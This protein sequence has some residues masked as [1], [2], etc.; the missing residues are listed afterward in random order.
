MLPVISKIL[1]NVM[2]TQYFTDNNLLSSQ[3]YGFRSNRSTELATLEIM[4]RNIHHMNENCCPVNIYLDFSKAFDSL[5]YDILLSK[6]AYYGIQP[7]ALRLLTSYLQD[8]CQ[9][10]QLDNV[11]S[12][13]HP[14]TC[15]IPQGSVLGPLLF[16]VFINDITF[17]E[18]STKFD[19]IMYA[20]DTTLASTLENFGTLNDVT[21]LERELNQEITKVYSWLLSNK[22]MLTTAKSKFM[23]FFKVPKV[24]SRLSLTIAGNPIEQVNEFN[25]LGITL[26]QNITW[27]PHITKMAI[28]IARV[29]G[30]LNKLKHI[31]PQHILLTIYNSLIQP[32]FIYGLYLWG[33]NCKRLKILQKKAV[34]ILAFRPYI[35]HSTPIFKTLKILKLEDLYTMQLYKFY[36]KNTNNLLPSYFNSFT[37][38]YNNENHNHDLRY[39]IL[40]LPMT[41]H[42]YY[43]QC[44]KYQ[45]L[46]LIRE[47]PHIDRCT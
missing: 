11:K 41:R 33:L 2:H 40:R 37:P 44:T 10:V 46:R 18:A 35:S 17:T 32:H 6:L 43:V 30:V 8:K 16:N 27:K 34:R 42:E 24:V 7:N 21:N 28:K 31:F 13:E 36:Y 1:E 20:D 9:Y 29:I 4:D 23:I 25:F 39:R 14:T 22:L 38:Y 26:D 19:F 3:Q 12:C 5:N 47:T 15:G 45:L